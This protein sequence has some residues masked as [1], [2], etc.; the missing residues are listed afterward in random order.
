MKPLR[1]AQCGTPLAD[2][3]SECPRCGTL[4]DREALL[5]Q[6][7]RRR[8]RRRRLA[9]LAVL[10]VALSAVAAAVLFH[11][12]R[13]KQDDEERLFRTLSEVP[14]MALIDRYLAA[15]PDGPHVEQVTL[16][17]RQLQL[18][19][20]E[21]S[22]LRTAKSYRDFLDFVRRHP[23]SVL[24]Q[25]ATFKADSLLWLATAKD[26]S[27]GA[28]AHYL[29]E[30]PE[31]RHA[32]EAREMV[33]TEAERLGADACID[34]FFRCV[35]AQDE[36]VLD[37]VAPRLHRFMRHTGRPSRG[38]VLDFMH[39]LWDETGVDELRFKVTKTEARKERTGEGVMIR[40]RFSAD[41]DI[42]RHFFSY[43]PRFRSYLGN[44]LLDTDYR[45]VEFDFYEET[46][47]EW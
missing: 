28:F 43:G 45:I 32:E 8:R 34:E 20:E 10:L 26:G 14:N 12:T 37:C 3:T 47:S 13:Q 40:V 5:A 36:A 23:R 39:E 16:I 1:C 25:E 15:Y 4:N 29:Q 33:V 7:L 17:R 24:V 27:S 41:C 38:L 30:L 42:D 11:L 31:G 22:R 2:F 35:N 9:W 18:E 46:K 19:Q 21:W 44:A 6:R